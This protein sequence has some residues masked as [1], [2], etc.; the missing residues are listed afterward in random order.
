M[1]MGSILIGIIDPLGTPAELRV[2]ASAVPF[3][4]L[5]VT[6]RLLKPLIELPPPGWPMPPGRVGA[7]TDE[8]RR[9]GFPRGFVLTMF[10]GVAQALVEAGAAELVD[11]VTE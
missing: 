10:A 6:V 2:D 1:S 8:M 7:P 4:A 11:E 3:T 9:G 5:P